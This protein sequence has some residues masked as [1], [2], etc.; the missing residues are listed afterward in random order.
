MYSNLY[1]F[2]LLFIN[3]LE[4]DNKEIYNLYKNN[5]NLF[6]EEKCESYFSLLSSSKEENEINYKKI[7]QH[8]HLINNYKEIMK[9]LNNKKSNRIIIDESKFKTTILKVE[10]FILN[11]IKNILENKDYTLN[12]LNKKKVRIINKNSKKNFLFLYNS[13]FRESLFKKNY[14]FY[15]N[16]INEKFN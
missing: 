12:I 7:R 1:L 8:F 10:F 11:K 4:K 5:I 15:L 9:K 16:K 3:Y 6:F 13:K 14:L 2:D